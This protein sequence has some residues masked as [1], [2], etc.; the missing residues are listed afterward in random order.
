MSGVAALDA[1]EREYQ[2][3]VRQKP[4]NSVNLDFVPARPKPPADANDTEDGG[5]E[6]DDLQ[7]ICSYA[8]TCDDDLERER[9]NSDDEDT[10]EY[11]YEPLREEE[12]EVADGIEE[13]PST[14][15]APQSPPVNPVNFS[16]NDKEAIKKAM[17]QISLPPPSWGGQLSDAQLVDLAKE[18]TNVKDVVMEP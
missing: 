2:A 11:E 15:K 9:L 18:A 14:V 5:M 1:L 17:Q 8:A 3:V 10:Q 4:I 12:W 6:Y 13:K 16:E 7:S